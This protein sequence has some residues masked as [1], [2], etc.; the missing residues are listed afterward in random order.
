MKRKQDLFS[1]IQ[2]T[3]NWIIIPKELNIK[4]PLYMKSAY[5]LWYSEI[6]S[7][8][9]LF[10]RIKDSKIDMRIH[11]NAVKKLEDLCF[12]KVV[13]VFDNLNT[14]NINS[15]IKKNI[16]FIIQNKQIYMPFFMMQIQTKNEKADLKEIYEL[17]TDAEIIL[18]GHLSGI[19]KNEMIIKDISNLIKKDSRT[20]SKALDILESMQ[21]I[22]IEK[23][24]RKKFIYFESKEELYNRFM[25]QN[26]LAI[27]YSFYIKDYKYK[28]NII[29]SGY[30]ALA[31]YSTL[32]EENIKTIAIDNK[33]LKSLDFEKYK[34]EKEDAKYKIEVWDRNPFIFSYKDLVNPLY[35]IRFFK[36][37][38][39]EG[40]EYALEEIEKD[41]KRRF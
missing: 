38:E 29:Y 19:I 34:C 8:K 36:D 9:V 33:N 6:S 17:S 28:E 11:K 4:V 23:I 32:I 24:G 5:D 41:I 15:L 30:T 25:K 12:C 26:K 39:D 13:L 31:K 16:A 22:N 27:K 10:L 21:Y 18:I 2:N 1:Y 14:K 7:F 35:I 20:V 3:T 40:I 37:I